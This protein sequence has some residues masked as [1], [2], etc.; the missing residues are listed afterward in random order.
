MPKPPSPPRPCPTLPSQSP[1]FTFRLDE[2][3]GGDPGARTTLMIRNI[4]NK[5]SQAMMLSVLLKSGFE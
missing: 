5:Y 1:Q 2:A 3:E 4:P